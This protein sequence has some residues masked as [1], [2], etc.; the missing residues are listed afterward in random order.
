MAQRDWRARRSF[1]LIEL[2]VVIAIIAVLIG[3][4]VPAVQKVRE[5][6]QRIACANNLKNIGLGC[7]DYH[8]SYLV[9]PSDNGNWAL[10]NPDNSQQTYGYAI[11][12]YIE[13]TNQVGPGSL[14]GDWNNYIAS[15]SAAT[16]AMQ[17]IKIYICP[18]RRNTSL[19]PFLDY[20]VGT[21]AIYDC[22]VPWPFQTIMA[23]YTAT[24]TS[25][26]MITDADGT[27][28]TLLL[29]HKGMR[30]E[31][32][33]AISGGSPV[34]ESWFSNNP[35]EHHRSQF[36]FVQDTNHDAVAGPGLYNMWDVMGSP[37]PSVCPALFA[38]GSVRNIGY[39]QSTD[40]YGALWSWDDGIA[41]GG[42]AVSQ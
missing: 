19:G 3:L 7:H 24:Q 20:G 34:D 33:G 23:N 18:G 2:L 5:A 9:F 27:A 15:Q 28:N 22:T 8:D 40:T 4:L 21:H 39:N 12:P 17:P 1:T 30:P 25:L 16:R 37:H 32:Y 26:T 42:S 11:L 14:T 10:N 29:G 36:Y 31:D 35:S 13:Q 6:A 38:D 41:L